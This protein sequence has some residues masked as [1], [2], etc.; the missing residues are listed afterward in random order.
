MHET[1]KWYE[2]KYRRHLCDMHIDDWDDSFLSSFTAEDYFRNLKEANVSSVMLYYQSHTGLCN[3]PTRTA[4]MHRAFEGREDEMQRLTEMFQRDGISVV[5]YYSVI[6]NVWAHDN[7]P[8][9]RMLMADGRSRRCRLPNGEVTDFEVA[10]GSRYGLCCPNNEEYRDFVYGQVDEM[11]EFFTPDGLF[12]DMLYWAHPCYCE[13]C[14][15]RWKRET[16]MDE[17]PTND[18][19]DDPLWRR[20]CRH[21]NA[22]IGEFAKSITD[23]VHKRAPHLTVQHNV[24][25]AG[26]ERYFGT[27]NAVNRASEFCGGDLSGGLLEESVVCKIFREITEN[28]PFEYMFPKCE[29]SLYKHTITKT[30]DHIEAAI[31]LAAAHHGATVVIDAIDPV[32]TLDSRFYKSVGEVFEKEKAFEEY[33]VGDTVADIGVV[34]GLESKGKLRFGN[35]YNNHTATV[36]FIKNM[37]Q[38]GIPVDVI[39]KKR[40]ISKYKM[41]FAACLW[42]T[43]DEMCDMLLDYV[44]EGGVLMFSGATSP[45]F[46]EKVL[47]GRI[48][49]MS[50]SNTC[51]FSPAKEY[52]SL[53]MDCNED[54]PLHIGGRV[55]MLE[56]QGEY[57]TLA[58][59][60]L[61]YIVAT[62][63]RFA[64][65]HSDPPGIKTNYPAVIEK[66]YGKGTVIYS[67]SPI[68]NEDYV[69][70]RRI[71]HN[72][73]D[74]YVGSD[75]LTVKADSPCNIETIVYKEKNCLYVNN[76]LVLDPNEK[77]TAI[78]F[79]IKIMTR[80][81]PKRITRIPSGEKIDFRYDGKYTRFYTKEMGIFDMY[82][83][84]L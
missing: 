20:Y 21:R 64:S 72:F 19:T 82:R 66:K 71:I 38:S 33:F 67:I 36:S 48:V 10:G 42:E 11:L 78:G 53:F 15:A 12:F 3:Y 5:G 6:Y 59:L 65:I 60:T 45:Y 77:P 2:N 13:S 28:Q 55:P 44:S 22:W 31:F 57:K 16:G 83:I 24:S 4:R 23:H 29:P 76:V 27:G 39:S 41:I 62:E 69:T 61:P 9:W 30:K 32:G 7:H 37:V 70:Y 25:A 18:S 68:E 26:K 84:E 75:N 81:A 80:T 50:N 35:E 56:L 46:I 8:E 51:Y 17:L 58:T 34:Y 40:D 1:K 14:K 52:E 63:T 49:E 47:G 43:E 54:Y 79:E 73:I 74:R